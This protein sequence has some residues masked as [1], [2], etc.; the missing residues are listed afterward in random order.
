MKAWEPILGLVALKSA[1]KH[2]SGEASLEAA[3]KKLK[4]WRVAYNTVYRGTSSFA[5]GSDLLEHALF[6]MDSGSPVFKLLP[7]DAEVERVIV[8]ARVL[9]YQILKRMNDRM[10]LGLAANLEPI[11][12]GLT[13]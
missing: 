12:S 1:R 11:K 13:R 3:V 8:V 9:L 7:G 5:H 10:G 2:W 4:G 6:S